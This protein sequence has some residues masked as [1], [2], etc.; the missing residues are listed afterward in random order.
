MNHY[1]CVDCG[2]PCGV[3]D[4]VWVLSRNDGN[5]CCPAVE[6]IS[7]H[8]TQE[9]AEAAMAAALAVRRPGD[10]NADDYDVGHWPVMPRTI[11][12]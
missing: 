6:W 2:N 4:G 12:P 7:I 10:A 5:V 11:E 3:G 8:A 9:S 1:S